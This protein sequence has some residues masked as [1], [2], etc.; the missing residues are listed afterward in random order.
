M[1]RVV[2]CQLLEMKQASIVYQFHSILILQLLPPMPPILMPPPVELAMAALA[3]AVPIMCPISIPESPVA[4]AVALAALF[5]AMD[6]LEI[7]DCIDDSIEDIM[8][9]PELMEELAELIAPISIF[10]LIESILSS[11]FFS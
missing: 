4:V 8:S 7:C 2:T 11:Q 1:P 3:D 5:T 9:I 10:I 6:I